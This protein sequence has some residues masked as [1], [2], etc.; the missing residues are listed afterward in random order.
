MQS[1]RQFDKSESTEENV[2][3]DFDDPIW[4]DWLYSEG[5]ERIQRDENSYT[6]CQYCNRNAYEL[7]S[8]NYWYWARCID[9]WLFRIYIFRDCIIYEKEYD[10]GG[11]AESRYF[12]IKEYSMSDIWDQIIEYI[13]S[14]IT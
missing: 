5:F 4:Y 14:N 6:Y 13:K 8:T 11:F 2:Y 3:F 1:L 7:N 9:R 12:D 10:C